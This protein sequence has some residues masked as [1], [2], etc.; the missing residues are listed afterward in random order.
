MKDSRHR[1]SAASRKSTA[2]LSTSPAMT[3]ITT[4]CIK[5][6]ARAVA[7]GLEAT[8]GESLDEIC[9]RAKSDGLSAP[10]RW[11]A[12]QILRSRCATGRG[13]RQV[14][15]PITPI[16]PRQYIY[17]SHLYSGPI[18]ILAP[19]AVNKL[20]IDKWR[21]PTGPP[22]KPCP[23]AATRGTRATRAKAELN[24][25]KLCSSIVGMGR[26]SH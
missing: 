4:R 19:V 24:N 10:A 26:E 1:R 16:Q 9:R 18:H 20:C 3:V 21:R 22:H 25:T 11:V 6:E 2:R 12:R 13:I 14:H 17:R 7:C 23:P 8:N 15:T 5:D